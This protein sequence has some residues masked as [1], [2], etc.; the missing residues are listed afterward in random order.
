[1]SKKLL[2]LDLET[3][4][5][6]NGNPY[7]VNNIICAIGA[8]LY[9]KP[10]KLWHFKSKHLDTIIPELQEML[11]NATVI[12]V[13]LKFDLAWLKLIGYD[14]DSI[15]TF[16]LQL[17]EFLITNQTSSYASLDA[18]AGKYLNKHK[19]DLIKENYWTKSINT[20]IIPVDELM[21]YLTV[22]LTL[23]EELYY[24]LNKQLEE[25]GKTNLMTVHSMDQL[26]LLDMEYNGIQYDVDGSL[27]HAKNIQT[28][29]DKHTK[30]LQNYFG[31]NWFNPSSPKHLSAALY[32]GTID[33]TI[34]IP[35][36][37]F[38]SGKKVGH[39]RYK[40][41]IITHTLP[42]IIEPLKGTESATEG[43]W[44][45]D[46]TTL[47][48]IKP[49]KTVKKVLDIILEIRR[50]A[51]LNSTYLEGFPKRITKM[52]WENN[53]IH[54]TINQCVAVTGRLSSTN[55]NQQNLDKTTKQFCISKYR[56]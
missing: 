17:A 55:P 39:T 9:D 25:Q 30:W 46:E 14:L 32:G 49:D 31:S 11:Y 35:I 40:K 36:G 16:D 38:K 4:I 52:H 15:A 50:L 48:T 53:L 41:L 21:E 42:R 47:L 3:T 24:H 29:I 2:T 54:S 56:D 23:T 45:T 19:L 18:M 8:K 33:E 27:N 12:G 26:V 28:D 37:S 5:S 1:M 44:S 43:V 34:R 6:N 7:D 51:K 13:N 20:D 22:D 10:E